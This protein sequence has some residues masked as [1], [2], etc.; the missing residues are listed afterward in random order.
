MNPQIE[1]TS[2]WANSLGSIHPDLETEKK[3][4]HLRSVLQRFRD[5]VATLTS[6]IKGQFPQ[7][8]IHDV[9]HLDALWETADLIAG[10]GYPLNPM[11]AFVLGGAI[12]L[13]DAAHCFEAYEGGLSA[14]RKTLAWRDAYAAELVKNPNESPEVREQYCDFA[15]I[16]LLHARQ[17]EKLGEREWKS[18]NGSGSFFLIEDT[19][20]RARYGALIGKIAASHNWS[21]DDVQSRLRAQFNAP[22]GGPTEWRVDPIK[23]ACLL[24]CADA[25]HLDDRRAPDFLFALIRRS[26]ISLDHWKAQNCLA[27]ADVDQSDPTKS[28]LLFTSTRAFKPG[29]TKAWWVA[30][31]AVSVLDAEINASNNLLFS[32]PQ[33]DSG[34]PAF[35]IRKVTGANS[36]VE[37]SKSIETED[38]KPTNAKIH[39]GNLE[40]LVESLGG[41]SLNGSGDNFAIVL[42][43]IIQNARDAIAARRALAANY[44]GKILV[45]IS[46]KSGAQ[47]FVE[48]R[49]DGIGMSERTMVSALLDFGT[50][51][52][53]SDLVQSEL[54]GLRSSSFKPVGK[55]GIGF[56]AVFMVASEVLVVSRRFDAGLV[57]VTRLH[58]ADGLTL[59]PI[60]AKGGD[61]NYDAMST[62]SIR[63]TVNEP[64]SCLKD[65][66][67]NGGTPNELRIPLRNYLAAKIAGLDV[68]VELQIEN[69]PAKLIH[70]SVRD[71]TAGEKMHKWIKDLTFVEIPTVNP[72][73]QAADFVNKNYDRIRKIKHEG[74]LVGI[75]ALFDTHAGGMQFLTTDT[76]GGLT[77]NVMRGANAYLGYM[78]SYPASAKRDPAKKIAPPE[79]LQ[80]WANEQISILKG[81][82]PTLEQFYWMASSMANLD[83]DPIDI[84]NFPI[85]NPADGQI[86]LMQFDQLFDVLQ[87]TPIASLMHRQTGFSETN[88]PPVV[89]GGLPT[90]R[91]LSTGCL[92]RLSVENGRPNYLASLLGCLLRLVE[93]RG[94]ELV[95]EVKP[96][97][98]NTFIGILDVLIIKLNSI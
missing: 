69:E 83:L 14:V 39:V 97:V 27:R 62:T 3:R 74:Q 82:S 92:I 56:Y 80:A 4:A 36:P 19:D 72:N 87:K 31:D 33:R 51:F 17:A 84:I 11:E 65:R 57:D 8:T 91:P 75:A 5:H 24:R 18:E 59:R 60:L 23:I 86:S 42:R 20:L 48:V 30:Y 67:I 47:S 28:S 13:H 38:W 79:V 32:R 77:N 49:D 89:I 35:K 52:W 10:P 63:L 37:L 2:L 9:T 96:N 25:A 15:A 90:L 53:A 58:F 55:Y 40:K 16:R 22:G 34:S 76:I 64:I 21:I 81:R 50:S 85:V 1:K 46:S 73:P 93:Q 66:V 44:T 78:E 68:A 7:L 43:E 6:I 71:L 29:D 88:V 12:L 41:Q 45:K 95:Y 54:P 70:E 26:G 94:R 61:E 98:M